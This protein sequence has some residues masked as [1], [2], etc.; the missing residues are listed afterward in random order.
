MSTQFI[1]KFYLRFNHSQF[2]GIKRILD[3]LFHSIEIR[4]GL[5]VVAENLF[6]FVVDF[7]SEYFWTCGHEQF[8]QGL[9]CLFRFSTALSCSGAKRVQRN[10]LSFPQGAMTIDDR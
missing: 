10:G 8:K 3:G 7:G 4:R 5:V 2:T 1:Y 6:H 9:H